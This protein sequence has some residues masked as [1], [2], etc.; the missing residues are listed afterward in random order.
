[1]DTLACGGGT[2]VASG[3]AVVDGT[4]LVV[5]L[6]LDNIPGQRSPRVDAKAS[7]HSLSGKETLARAPVNVLLC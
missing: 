7:I 1:M 2:V 5:V 6:L 4:E 3:P